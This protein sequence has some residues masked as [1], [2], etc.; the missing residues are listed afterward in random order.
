[1]GASEDILCNDYQFWR[2]IC[3]MLEATE[4]F[5]DVSA[6]LCGLVGFLE[7]RVVPVRS[8]NCNLQVND[9]ASGREFCFGLIQSER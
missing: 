7:A 1:M 2:K 9:L 5:V 6:A 4:E 3:F 8:T